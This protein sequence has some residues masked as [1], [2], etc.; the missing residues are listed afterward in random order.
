MSLTVRL[1]GWDHNPKTKGKTWY[2]TRDEAR[3]GDKLL[4]CTIKLEKA[5]C[6]AGRE[7]KIYNPSQIALIDLE[8]EEIIKKVQNVHRKWGHASYKE[9]VCLFYYA[10]SEFEGVTM[11]DLDQWKNKSGDFCTGCIE[12]AMK[13]HAKYKSTKPLLSAVPGQINVGDLMFVEDNQNIKKPLYVQVDVCTKYVTGVVMNS[14][15]EVDCTT[16]II[17][18]QAHYY[19]KGC[20]MEALTFDREPGVVPLESVLKEHGVKLF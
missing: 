1:Q 13:E 11:D 12:G 16:S 9:M 3:Y 2:F 7:K 17:T 6:F 4:H 18:M 15:K 8:D 5:Q 19:V 14:R 20:R 10:P